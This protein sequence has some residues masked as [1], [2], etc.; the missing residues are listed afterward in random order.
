[1]APPALPALPEE[2]AMQANGPK[3]A[4]LLQLERH[5]S[6][7]RTRVP[8]LWPV[9]HDAMHAHLAQEGFDLAAAWPRFV[10]AQGDHRH[11]TEAATAVA[12]ELRARLAATLRA[13]PYTAVQPWLATVPG[14]RVMV[15]SSTAEDTLADPNAGGNKTAANVTPDLRAVNAA[16]VRVLLA[17]LGRRSLAQQLRAGSRLRTPPRLS[18]FLQVMVGESPASG[19]GPGPG[20]GSV[21]VSG[22]AFSMEPQGDTPGVTTLNATFGH[23]EGVVVGGSVAT[24]T[25]HVDAD[26]RVH[27]VEVPKAERLAPD[28]AS[29]AL[30]RRENGA[31]AATSACPPDLARRVAALATELRNL[32][33]CAV[34]IEWTYDPSTDTLWLLQA[35]PL[36]SQP[37]G[38][39]THLDLS[40]I[41]RD[42]RATVRF[43]AGAGVEARVIH[44]PAALLVADTL[45][46]ALA[47]Y[48]AEPERAATRAVVIRQPAA[49][50]SHEAITFRAAGVMV[51]CTAAASMLGR[52]LDDGAAVALDPQTGTAARLSGGAA[53][54]PIVPGLLHHPI[55]ARLSLTTGRSDADRARAQ[56]FLASLWA[57]LR[58]DAPAPE[59][60][61]E[62]LL[63]RVVSERAAAKPL[64]LAEA[65]QALD[66]PTP[67]VRPAAF[68]TVLR[69]ALD[70]GRLA[71]ADPSLRGRAV[72]VAWQTLLELEA[73]WHAQTRRAPRMAR[74]F[75]LTWLN[76]VLHQEREPSVLRGDSVAAL[77]TDVVRS[78]RLRSRLPGPMP[79]ASTYTYAHVY[80][81]VACRALHPDTAEA[82]R[83]FTGALLRKG[84]W[85][86]HEA[87]GSLLTQLQRIDAL[88][89]WL[90]SV[91][92]SAWNAGPAG[93][94][95]K[96]SG[97]AARLLNR[98]SGNDSEA[99]RARRTLLALAQPLAQ[100][101]VQEAWS[102][103]AAAARA[104]EASA[105]QRHAWERPDAFEAL[106][107]AT[108]RDHGAPWREAAR[109]HVACRDAFTRRAVLQCLHTR[110]EL[111]DA[112]LKAVLGSSPAVLPAEARLERA[113][114]L[115]EPYVGLSCML[116]DLCRDAGVMG[117]KLRMATAAAVAHQQ[118]A[119]LATLRHG[120]RTRSA[121]ALLVPGRTFNVAL[122]TLGSGAWEQTGAMPETL[123]DLFGM[124]H[125]NALAAIAR[126]TR[127][128]GQPRMPGAVE[129]LELMVESIQVKMGHGRWPGPRE[130]SHVFVHPRL[131]ITYGLALR[132]HGVQLTV[133][134]T[135][136]VQGQLDALTLGLRIF[137]RNE[138]MH[139]MERIVAFARVVSALKGWSFTPDG[140][141]RFHR[142]ALCLTWSL[143][144]RPLGPTDL[145]DLKAAVEACLMLTFHYADGRQVT[146]AFDNPA[147]MAALRR[148]A[149][150]AADDL[151]RV[152][153]EVLRDSPYI[154]AALMALASDPAERR[155]IARATL[156]A[157]RV[158]DEYWG[159]QL[160]IAAAEL[161]EPLP[162]AVDV[163]RAV[164]T[165]VL[166]YGHGDRGRGA[167]VAALAAH[168]SR[169]E[170]E[171]AIS[172]LLVRGFLPDEEVAAPD[173]AIYSLMRDA[174]VHDP[175]LWAAL[176]ERARYGRSSL[177][178]AAWARINAAAGAAAPQSRLK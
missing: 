86:A 113:L 43:I 80:E 156:G 76:A 73:V 171:E 3:A 121:A 112:A 147:E 71:A 67:A 52:W 152:P 61:L 30:A 13:H 56:R 4:R 101:D 138:E 164:S 10:A 133:G 130:L 148:I 7:P 128:T 175:A 109:R 84:S 158:C 92:L 124:A 149:P 66:G 142:D 150:R 144:P 114:R 59:P 78:R 105:R 161:G 103:V 65:L 176:G 168:R 28:A 75:A 16:M 54:A 173:H 102:W 5:L 153:A 74:L 126:L 89:G 87:L 57:A 21:P 170:L 137:G 41:A 70:V 14:A 20:P 135:L 90:D 132:E 177:D 157:P 17:Y 39:P 125:Q 97:G 44:E 134:A 50:T 145:G 151:W 6:D 8:P 9:S 11:L 172:D 36:Q 51:A 26:G 131:E 82:W 160:I 163:R 119:C 94:W 22:V 166:L 143:P 108:L 2:M 1:V 33:A 167:R 48:L 155:R 23:N 139:R 25:V 77:A 116:L 85:V 88:D 34:D 159:P 178:R 96:M 91:F 64:P 24:D 15:R 40:R 110:V 12:A 60:T 165:S 68:A 115:M 107:A 63:L 106:L 69:R 118:R 42:C 72:D 95:K 169:E 93:W 58:P 140:T 46:E 120:E 32:L 154:N 29:E 122:A 146:Y 136:G 35:R 62:G 55:P 18:L 38:A 37:V 98:G 81:Q 100:R 79:G 174:E 141:A 111:L 49:T 45:P 104:A 127:T 123:E 53:S 83:R 27:A 47:R 19:P 162:R 31:L 129:H 117:E 99:L